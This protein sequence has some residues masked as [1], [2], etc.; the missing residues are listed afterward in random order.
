MPSKSTDMI[1]VRSDE[2]LWSRRLLCYYSNKCQSVENAGL[3]YERGDEVHDRGLRL[4]TYLKI[5]AD[6]DAP[7]SGH[8]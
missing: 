1:D 2:I 3:R 6:F 8:V 5:V 7:L 4:G